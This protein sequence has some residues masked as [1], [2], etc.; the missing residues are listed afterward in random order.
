MSDLCW[1]FHENPFGRFPVMLL[2]DTDFFENTVKEAE[3]PRVKGDTPQSFQI[4]PCNMPNL[5]WNFHEN[6]FARFSAM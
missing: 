2:T 6:P 1:K 3:Y 5:S 4:V